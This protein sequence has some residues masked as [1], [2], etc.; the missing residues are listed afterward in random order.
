MSDSNIVD[1]PSR[2]RPTP[3]QEQ[4]AAQKLRDRAE[5]ISGLR[6]MLRKNQKLSEAGH[7]SVAK[8]VNDLLLR[9]EKERGIR[10]AEILRAAKIAS[11]NRWDHML[12]RDVPPEEIERRLSRQRT[13]TKHYK[14]IAVAW[15]RLAGYDEG[16][17]LLDVFGQ[18]DFRPAPAG[19]PDEGF[20]ELANRLW[21]VADGISKKY[22][23]TTFF[24]EVERFGVSPSP[25]RECVQQNAQKQN[26]YLLGEQIGIEY[27][28]LNTD[29]EIASSD[30][31]LG[32]PIELN[33]LTWLCVSEEAG[34]YLPVY[35][36]LILGAW[37]LGDPF[38][39]L[40]RNRSEANEA[41]M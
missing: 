38:P 9:I 18:V 11:K 35:P 25:T 6:E 40:I 22:D 23:L 33:Q 19:E 3:E 17:V 31:W 8:A 24:R 32:W 37:K 14:E 30:S 39:I 27:S 16:S 2:K 10:K 20:E 5:R 21:F 1:F 13:G 26:C 41:V 12:P 15:A 36:S 34:L 29:G 7:I 28:P 4:I